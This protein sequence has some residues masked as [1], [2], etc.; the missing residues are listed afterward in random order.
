MCDVMVAVKHGAI[1]ASDLQKSFINDFILS[2]KTNYFNALRGQERELERCLR[3]PIQWEDQRSKKHK[4][5]T[6]GIFL[7]D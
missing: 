5:L 2:A 1:C 7:L 4:Y 6:M 3:S